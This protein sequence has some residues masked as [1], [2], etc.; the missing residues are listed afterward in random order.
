MERTEQ[1]VIDK[2]SVVIY[3]EDYVLTKRLSAE[4]NSG[5]VYFQNGR[6]MAWQFL[7][8]SRILPLVSKKL[9]V[10]FAEIA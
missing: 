7:I 2:S 6:L 8:P 4:F 9:G 3:T 10:D 1:W 5:T